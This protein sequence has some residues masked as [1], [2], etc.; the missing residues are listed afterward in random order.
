MADV[1]EAVA[2][3]EQGFERRVVIKRLRKDSVLDE[4]LCRA[5]L[6]E[7]RIASQLHHANIVSILDFGI[8]DDT[9]FQALELVDGLDF[10]ELLARCRDRSISVPAELALHVVT[11]VAH[12]LDYAHDACGADGRALGIVHRDVSPNNIL[13]SSSGDVKLA[14]F[15][16][17]MA[18]DRLART[19][20]GYAK[21]KRAYMAPEQALVSGVDHRADVFSLGCVL[22]EAYAGTSPIAT[23]PMSD[24]VLAGNDIDP[25][26]SLPEDVQRIVRR[27]IRSARTQRYATAAEMASE[28]GRALAVRMTEDARTMMR[29]FMKQLEKSEAAPRPAGA[30]MFDLELVLKPGAGSARRFESVAAAGAPSGSTGGESTLDSLAPLEPTVVEPAEWAS[31]TAEA[32]HTVETSV[33]PV[34][35]GRTEHT[36][37]GFREAT[38]DSETGGQQGPVTVTDALAEA[39]VETKTAPVGPTPRDLSPLGTAI[40]RSRGRATDERVPGAFRRLPDAPRIEAVAPGAVPGPAPMVRSGGLRAGTGVLAALMLLAIIAVSAFVSARWEERP[41]RVVP[42]IPTGPKPTPSIGAVPANPIEARPD[43]VPAAA[44]LDAGFEAVPTEAPRR[45]RPKP[46][47]RARMGPTLRQLQASLRSALAAR[48]LRIADLALDEVAA[49]HVERWRKA[50]KRGD[51]VAARRAHQALLPRIEQMQVDR[52]ILTRRLEEVVRALERGIAGGLS[53]DVAAALE[54]EYLELSKA[55]SA[56]STPKARRALVGRIAS[57]EKRIAEASREP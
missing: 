31:T 25:D 42:P 35:P 19:Q 44:R 14:D 5:F 8:M 46:V 7:A 53:K 12:A 51:G 52:A 20:A 23:D 21:G 38:T 43:P 36:E 57:L 1:Y 27:A 16:I 33:A 49:P 50:V 22:H 29:A 18:R 2:I 45:R 15:G 37:V 32:T 28:C 11:E 6:D 4:E 47:K 13:L 3:G 30:Q 17:A 56:A 39:M 34:A 10:S 55:E 9:P 41:P 26:P 48:G 40:I 54:D 24:A